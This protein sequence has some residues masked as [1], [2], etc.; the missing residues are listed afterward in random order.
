MPP[1]IIGWVLTGNSAARL[2]TGI[3][4]MS[5][6]QSDQTPARTRYLIVVLVIAAFILPLGA[7]SSFWHPKLDVSNV[8]L[9]FLLGAMVAFADFFDIE[10]SVSSQTLSVS[11]S[12]AICFAAAICLGGPIGALVAAVSC[13]AVEVIQRRP[14][15][16]LA[17][18]VANYALTTLAAGLVYTSLANV[19]DTPIGSLT[20][21]GVMLLSACVYVVVNSTLMASVLSQVLRASPWSVLR[22]SVMGTLIESISLLT[23]GTLIPILREHGPLALILAVIPL[24][25]PYLAFRSYRETNRQTRETMELLADMLDR[26]DPYTSNH[27]QRVAVYAAGILEQFGNLS[28]PDIDTI[29]A[30]ARIH[31]LGKVSTNDQTLKKP[32]SLTPAERSA[33]QR[34]AADG[35]AIIGNLAMYRDAA[36]IV[37]HH[38]ERWDG[39][40]Y[41]DGLSGEHIPFGSRVIAVADT[42]DAMTSDRPYRSALSWCVALAEIQRS[43]GSQFD[44]R[45]VEAF[46]ASLAT[47]Q[48]EVLEANALGQTAPAA[49]S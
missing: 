18:N 20:N 27:S 43:A 2:P 19:H 41:P 13:V 45:I 25:G 47:R 1:T 6:A 37:R 17:L 7:Y 16:K 40:G 23:L 30:A 5:E 42:Y 10:I 34:H 35:A 32:D 38:H 4:G 3:M 28:A 36:T 24:L 48:P 46:E 33:I 9:A 11:V 44:P 26:R 12:S 29:L 22:F 15:L 14:R 49:P 8:F 21:A 39:S 31:D